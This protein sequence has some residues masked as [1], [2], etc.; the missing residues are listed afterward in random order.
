MNECLMTPKHETYIGY[1][2]SDSGIK[3]IEFVLQ[4]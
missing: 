3:N 2:V 1:W 4:N